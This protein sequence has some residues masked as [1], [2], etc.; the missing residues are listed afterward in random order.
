MK[1]RINQILHVFNTKRP[2]KIK[3]IPL[4]D[5]SYKEKYIDLQGDIRSARNNYMPPKIS[6]QYGLREYSKY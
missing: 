3:S 6:R 2:Q 4:E 5:L 1:R